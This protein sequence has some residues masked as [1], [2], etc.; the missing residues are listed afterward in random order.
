VLL[1]AACGD[2]DADTTAVTAAAESTTTTVAAETGAVT[3]AL[4][5]AFVPDDG[6]EGPLSPE[7][8]ACAAGAV[9]D[10][11]GLERTA[12]LINSAAYAYPGD[13]TPIFA[14][15]A[16]D[17]VALALEA[18]GGCVDLEQ[19][20]QDA[21]GYFGFT[22][23]LSSCV[24][25]ALFADG[26]GDAVLETFLAGTD[27][28]LA[29]GFTASY[30]DALADDCTEATHA[31]VVDDLVSY[32]GIGEER[33][34]CVADAFGQHAEFRGLLTLWMGV[35]DDTIDAEAMSEEITGVLAGCL[36]DDE[37]A[38]LGIEPPAATDTTTSVP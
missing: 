38:M 31:L 3:D 23:D 19:A 10:V 34:V 32:Y 4:V 13:P 11:I 14:Q 9:I 2:D 15:M 5:A 6:F 30:L 16:G 22:A 33:A 36:T 1:M 21:L 37:L 26:Y 20:T 18:V 7:A 28:A 8:A 24:G 27:P 17:E 29:E 25:A 12:G 35:A